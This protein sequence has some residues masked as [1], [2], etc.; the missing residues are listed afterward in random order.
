MRSVVT[1]VMMV[2]CL[3]H[4]WTVEADNITAYY[5]FDGDSTTGYKIAD[6]TVTSF[7]T[8]LLG[9]PVAIRDSVWLGDRDDNGA[10]EFTLNGSPTGRTSPGGGQFNQLL[11]GTAGRSNNYGVECCGQNSVT[12]ANGD[13]SAQRVLFNIPFNGSGIAYDRLTNTLYISQEVART[14]RHYTL[15]GRLLDTFNLN[16]ELVGLAYEEATDTFWGFNRVTNDLV[17]FNRSGAVLQDMDIPGFAPSNPWGGE[18]PVGAAATPE[19]ASMLLLGT[20]IVLAAA[21][22]RSFRQPGAAAPARVKG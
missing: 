7:D 6:G 22:R 20:G 9:Y 10:R 1:A 21:R 14:V 8:F 17:E 12:V 11:D 18:M 15:D 3:A 16:Q 13:W 5:L 19:P 2:A 4:A